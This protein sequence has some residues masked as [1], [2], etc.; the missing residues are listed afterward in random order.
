MRLELIPMPIESMNT[1]ALLDPMTM[2]AYFN[3]FDAR[4]DAANTLSNKLKE[5]KCV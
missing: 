5:L 1:E 4:L 3:A 2:E